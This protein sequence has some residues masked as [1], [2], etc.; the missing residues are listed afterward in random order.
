MNPNISYIP[1]ILF[2]C[3]VILSN[4]SNN[5]K[6]DNSILQKDTLN[7][8]SDNQITSFA[9]GLTCFDADTVDL[10]IGIISSNELL[11]PLARFHSDSILINPWTEMWNYGDHR[12]L[13]K[14]I[15]KEWYNYSHNN[16]SGGAIISVNG[17]KI[18]EF[19]CLM[20]WVVTFT[21]ALSSDSDST[22]FGSDIGFAFNHPIKQLSDSEMAANAHRFAKVK[23]SL[24][25]IDK[26]VD[27]ESR[28]MYSDKMYFHWRQSIIGI[29]EVRGYESESA[30]IIQ[31]DSNGV[32]KSL[33]VGLG[34]C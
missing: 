10:Y 19:A 18:A 12:T 33:Y 17:S 28:V 9:N 22:F 11:F 14:S 26:D 5:S 27:G 32:N 3:S 34:G 8:V 2:T 25:L 6:N 31:I 20:N 13:D 1:A 21:D 29:I 24:R 16:D 4:C 30:L 15:P 23:A 7:I